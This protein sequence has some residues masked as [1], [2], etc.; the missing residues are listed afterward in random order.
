MHKRNISIVIYKFNTNTATHFIKVWLLQFSTEGIQN[1]QT[2]RIW[3]KSDRS[4]SMCCIF[5]TE[6]IVK[7]T[8]DGS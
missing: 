6:D 2:E 4:S 3:K 7:A 8:Q 1:Y 5:I